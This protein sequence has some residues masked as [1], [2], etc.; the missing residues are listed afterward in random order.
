VDISAIRIQEIMATKKMYRIGPSC[1]SLF[2]YNVTF[3]FFKK[4]DFGFNISFKKFDSCQWLIAQLV[5][6]SFSVMKDPGS[7]LGEDICSFRY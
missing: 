4:I 1:L 7:N 3:N 6:R 2:L 5:E